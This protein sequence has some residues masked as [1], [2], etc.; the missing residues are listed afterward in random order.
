M[1]R[2]RTKHG[3]WNK[4]RY[5]T[6]TDVTETNHQRRSVKSLILRVEEDWNSKRF[7][8]GGGGS[9]SNQFSALSSGL[10]TNGRWKVIILTSQF[11][12]FDMGKANTQ[13]SRSRVALLQD[14]SS[15]KNR[16]F[17]RKDTQCTLLNMYTGLF[18]STTPKR[19]T[20]KALKFSI[21]IKL[22]LN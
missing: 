16:S 19:L 15:N 21:S 20:Q 1:E 5:F 4:C 3:G 17:P 14:E 22:A 13:N 2:G 9:R 10:R 7:Y 12:V 18:V 8:G 6:V 11:C